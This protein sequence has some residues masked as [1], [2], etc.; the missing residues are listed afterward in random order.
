[1]KFQTPPEFHCHPQSLDSASTPADMAVRE[2]ELGSG[3]LTAT[4]H[5]SLGAAYT[6]YELAKGNN[7][8]PI[9]G[10]EGYFRAEKLCPILS[11]HGIYNPKEY[12]KYFHFTTHFLDQDAF[13]VGV[14][15]LSEARLEPH[16][17]EI[18]PLFDWQQMEELGATN[19]T[20]GS[21]CLVGMAAWHL[22]DDRPDIAEDYYLRYRSLV[23]NG[24]FYAELFP[25]RCT[26]DWVAG[27]FVKIRE[28]GIEKELKFWP[29][30]GFRDDKGREL[31]AYELPKTKDV[32]SIKAVMNRRK[33][34]AVDWEF[35]SAREVEEFLQNECTPAVPDG[36][37][38]LR[39]NKFIL[40]MAQK[41]GDP[42]ILAGDVHY[43]S[44]EAKIVQDVR[45]AQSGNWRFYGEYSRRSA[46]ENWL[47]FKNYMDFTEAQYQEM[48]ENNQNWGS[49]FKDFNLKYQPSLPTKFYPSDT[50]GYTYKLI[51]KHGRMK[52]DNP[53]W[54]ARLEKEIEVLHRNGTIDL[55][56]Y[57]FVSEEV[58]EVAAQKGIITGAGRGSAAGVL[59]CYLLGVTHVDPIATGLSFDRFITLDRI[60]AGKM[61]D[62]D[63]DLPSR[64]FL[65]GVP[66]DFID[67]EMED[68]TV[69][70]FRK[71]EV[72]Q[73][74]SGLLTIEEA[75]KI[76]AEL[77]Q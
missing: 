59:L 7:L 70:T 76:N 42:I 14:R 27:I 53:V 71:N 6:I 49:R 69:R 29:K 20:F 24:N 35:I 25:H 72:V 48:L 10:L 3:A 30:K 73:T 44:K 8:T 56:P 54:K 45:L 63:Q 5:G 9:L 74:T 55:L 4:D 36:D 33:W 61:P 50:L 68:G 13:Q 18:K 26:H 43:S 11:S 46:D 47:Y 16:G 75:V 40:E 60:L 58:C 23:K 32:T 52:W 34:E 64:E 38:Q 41:Y 12:R 66:Q 77:L 31:K 39:A 67:I 28:N 37:V 21:G 2:V 65:M 51:E 15:L 57:F 62:L 22:L 19:S 1:M 17:S